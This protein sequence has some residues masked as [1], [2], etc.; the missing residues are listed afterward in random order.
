MAKTQSFADKIKKKS[1]TES[2][3]V[4]K[5]VYT[6]QS[7]DNGAWRFAEKFIKVP[8]GENESKII[9]EEIKNGKVL[10]EQN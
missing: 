6:Y 4:I 2:A 10:L 9:D 3:K 7:S 5:L 8:P 1:P